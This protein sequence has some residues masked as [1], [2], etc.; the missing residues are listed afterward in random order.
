MEIGTTLKHC[1]AFALGSVLTL[2]ASAE[3]LTLQRGLNVDLWLEWRSIDEMLA[4][5]VFLETYP[6]WRRVITRDMFAI[7]ADAGFD[8][9]RLPMDPGPLLAYGPGPA[10]DALIAD[11]RDG[12]ETAL[13]AG[14]KV[15]VDMHPIPRGEDI[16]G[17]ESIMGQHWPDYVA[18]VGRVA[19][20]LDG[21]APDRVAFEPLNEPTNDCEAV[22][23]GT[24]AAWPGMLAELHAAARDGAPELAVVLTGAC[25]SQAAA[26][27]ALDPALIADENVIWTFHSYSPFAYTHQGAEWTVHPMKYLWDL[28]YPPSLMTA[29]IA[30]DVTAEATRRMTEAEGATAD[31]S[32]I[33]DRIGEYMDTPDSAVADDIAAAAD[34]ADTHGIPRGR[35]L[36][37]EF[38]ALHTVNGLSQPREWYHAFLSDKRRAAEDAGMGWAVLGYAGG[39]GVAIDGDP[40]RRLSPGTCQA[41]GLDPCSQ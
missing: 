30:A 11:M 31:T 10:Q 29:E 35:I 38:G 19:E 20:A 5:P 36:L 15:I 40:D 28:P 39:M 9:V 8:F 6:D 17:M 14:L 32:A 41:L 2:P 37:G 21:L 22:F 34:W 12:A 16:G 18:L 23:S 1:I 13:A 7:L 26:L 27:A 24:P 33:A 4:D 25:W 3:P